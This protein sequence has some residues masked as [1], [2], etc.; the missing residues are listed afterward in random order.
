MHR[1]RALSRRA[2]IGLGA[3]GVAGLAGAASMWDYF[4]RWRAS[5][6]PA[7]IFKGDAP[8]GEVWELWRKRGW[9]R[10]GSHYLKLGRNVQCKVCPN[11]C[12]LAPGDRSHC[13]NKVNCDGKLYTLA[14]ANPCTF[15]VDPVEK[16]PLFHFLPGS[17]T[18]S[19]ATSGCVFRCLNCQNWE[20]SQ[21]KPE[22]TK[23]PRG[24][25]LRMRP[26]L[27]SGFSLDQMARLSLFPA[28]AAAVA[29]ALD[30]PSLSYT[31][32][33]PT[34]FY[35][36]AVDACKAAR[37]RK[38]R[39]IV[40]SCGSIED[41]AARDL[42]Q[43][44]DAAH[45]DLKGFDEQVYQK[46]N[47]GRLQPILNTLKMLKELG[48]WF[49]IINLVVPTYTDDLGLIRR[50][51]GWIAKELG[52]D[53]PLHFSRFHPQHKLTYLAPTPVETL[54]RARD[55]G[56]SE[57]LR[58]V[59]IGNVPGLEG[60]ET[61]WCPNCKKAVVERNIYAVTAVNLADGNCR[62]CGT[63]IAGVWA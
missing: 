61:T 49:E 24:A 57:G 6:A 5:E 22:E 41:R 11:N 50:M 36:Y 37:E 39:N 25:E 54:V 60:A 12:L 45:V 1:R 8:K 52:P 44:V 17:R 20:I 58:Y 53:Q 38:L 15:H 43:L 23:D 14:Y 16:K 19:L 28:D 31:Y 59:Y 34:A 55:A 32:S 18:F 33:E 10:E 29:E 9:V 51:C 63:R 30:C 7:D 2:A 46:L 21:K 26:P 3:A 56:R 4:T 27:P 48:V 40:V 13:R 62:S 42:Y 35:E 47:S